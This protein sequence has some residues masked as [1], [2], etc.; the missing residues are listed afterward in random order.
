VTPGPLLLGAGLGLAA[1]IVVGLRWP[2]AWLALL[3]ASGAAAASAAIRVLAGGGDWEWWSSFRVGGEQMQL[4]LDGV[5][6]LFLV[7]VTVVGAAGAVYA[8]GY[9]S[10]RDYPMSAPRGRMWWSALVLNLGAVLLASNGLQFL[11]SWELFTISA[12]FLIILDGRRREVRKAGWLYLVASHTGTVGLFAFFAA[13]A[14]QTGSWDL[15]PVREQVALA[16]LFWLALFGFAVKGGVFPLHIWLPS[17]HANAPS[18]VSAILSGVA[19]KMGVYGLV[20]FSGWLPLPGGAGWVVIGLGATGALLGIAFA[21]AQNDLKRLLAYSSVE[22]IGVIMIG[23]GAALLGAAHGDASWGRLALAGALLH[24]WNHGLFKALLFFSAGS[25]L[26]ATGTRELS[27][28][29]GLWRVMPWTAGLFALGA[30]AVCALPPLNGFVSEW[31]IY[32]G[33]IDGAIGRG[34]LAWATMPAAIILA[35]T[36]ALTLATFVKASAMVFLGAPRTRA[37]AHAHECG[38]WMRAP[39]IALAAGCAGLGLAPVLV[40]P[41]LA[42]ATSSWHPAWAGPA[43][44]APLAT[45][46]GVQLTLAVA[47]IA[48]AVGLWRYAHARGTRRA[49]TWDC[50]YAAPSARMQYTSGSFGSLATQWFSLALQ[51]ERDLRRPRGLFP[52]RAHHLERVPEAVLERII[53]PVATG[54]LRVSTL[55]RQLQHGRLQFYIAYV[56][57]GLAVLGLMVWWEGLR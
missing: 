45:L 30:L 10:D 47:A 15:G 20:R 21:L 50:G 24:V 54:I 7:L 49:P 4:R 56:G 36:G 52:T 35:M 25:I 8:C 2:R 57:V 55:V 14:A 40:W 43:A 16:P 12:F 53:Q 19:I 9:W 26:H 3:L 22:N 37:V 38:P 28:L 29:G 17:A 11:I 39:M 31:L 44:L 42:R 27:R 18:H 23:L 32:L 13:L 6:A 1:A 34:P 46:G 33:L 48:A 51:P 41:A 5:S